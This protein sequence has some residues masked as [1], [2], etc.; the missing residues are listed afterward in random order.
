M[1]SK[2]IVDL[3]HKVIHRNVAN[4]NPVFYLGTK[5]RKKKK[6]KNNKKQTKKTNSTITNVRSLSY[7]LRIYL[8]LS[9]NCI[10]LGTACS[11]W[12]FRAFP[13]SAGNS[14]RKNASKEKRCVIIFL[15]ALIYSWVDIK[16]HT[17]K[18][19][20]KTM[21]LWPI[22]CFQLWWIR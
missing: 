18:E 16:Q 10:I 1:S 14:E 13:M 17:K 9:V 19:K 22:I 4:P 5:K 3:C 2:I 6:T 11:W 12:L 15:C 7:I 8:F 21:S 20:K